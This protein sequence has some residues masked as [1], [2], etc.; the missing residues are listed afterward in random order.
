MERESEDESSPDPPSCARTDAKHVDRDTHMKY[1]VAKND[2]GP[3]RRTV[4]VERK[5]ES[6]AGPAVTP[7][8][9]ETSEEDR[10]TPGRYPALDERVRNIE[11]HLAVRYGT[12]LSPPIP[13]P[14]C[15]NGVGN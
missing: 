10:M 8:K 14:T 3:L 7:V 4:N 13:S 9:Q 6:T 12:Y 15:V 5:A 11:T 1:D 2:E